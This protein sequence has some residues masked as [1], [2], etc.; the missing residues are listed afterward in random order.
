MI[1]D[2][3]QAARLA[4]SSVASWV[5][6][7]VFERAELWERQSVELMENGAVERMVVQMVRKMDDF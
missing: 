5:E 1:S 7:T 2:G 3:K 4:A 6:L